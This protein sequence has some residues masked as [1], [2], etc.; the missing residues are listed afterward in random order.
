MARRPFWESKSLSQ[1]TA[2]EW[3]SLCD[4]CGLCC[5][6]RFEDEAS[7]EVVPTRVACKLFDA[8]RCR[9]TD[10][11]N[12]HGQVPDCIKL[13]PGN[14]A[15]LKWMPFSCAYRRLDE[16]KPLPAWHPLITGDPASVHAAGV[17]VKGKTISETC[18]NDPEDAL[19]F[20]AREWLV[21]RSAG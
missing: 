5:L 15:S 1:M 10:Y 21:D 13:T 16:G 11:E 7:G 2:H 19:D 17:S 14:V 3:E 18:L 20:V 4:G 6:V 9:C 12:R 8:D